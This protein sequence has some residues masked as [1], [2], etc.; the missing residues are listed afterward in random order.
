MIKRLIPLAFVCL[1]L[2][3]KSFSI[4]SFSLITKNAISFVDPVIT[5]SGPVDFCQGGFV[6]LKT[7][8]TGDTYQWFN[9]GVP[10][11]GETTTTFKAL[12]IGNYSL[13]I[14]TGGVE[15]ESNK[16]IVTVFA[17]PTSSFTT[18]ASG[19]NC[20]NE[21]ISFTN[22]STG[23]GLTYLWNFGDSNATNNTSTDQNPKHTFVGTTG[24]GT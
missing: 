15:E 14:T 23:T 24:N 13:K 10:I 17:L 12:V 5:P 18:N 11:S 6:E 16:V 9:N 8:N 19:A 4:P 20:S 2:C 3:N 1:F 22:T 21:E 7:T